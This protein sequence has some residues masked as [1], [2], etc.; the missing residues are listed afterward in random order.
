MDAL[1]PDYG[2]SSHVGYITPATRRIVRERGPCDIHRRSFQALCYLKR[3]RPQRLT[4]RVAPAPTDPAPSAARGWHYRLRGYR[5]LATNVWI[6]GYELDVV[7]RR[8][9]TARLLRGQGQAWGAARGPARD[10]QP[11]EKNRRL[12][13][14]AEVWLAPRPEG[15]VEAGFDVAAEREGKLSVVPDAF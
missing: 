6:G 14:A 4:R 7:V 12:R 15:E 8:G 5:V 9:R 1:F 3:K 11:R 13:Q 2:F 10:G